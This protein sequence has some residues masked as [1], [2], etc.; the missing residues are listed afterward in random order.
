MKTFDVAL[1]E[2]DSGWKI[3]ENGQATLKLAG[4]TVS[5]VIEPLLFGQYYFAV[6]EHGELV[7]NKVPFRPGGGKSD[8]S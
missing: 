3:T 7:A 5:V 2:P 8:R 4:G 6:Y 1:T